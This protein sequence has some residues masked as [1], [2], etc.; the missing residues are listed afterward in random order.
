MQSDFYHGLLGGGRAGAAVHRA[1]GV[2][3]VGDV[4]LE[5]SA[6][7]QEAA[8]DQ[9]AGRPGDTNTPRLE[10]LERGDRDVGQVPQFM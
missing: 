2:S 10:H 8:M 3:A 1:L 4:V 7:P 5:K 6:Y 9:G